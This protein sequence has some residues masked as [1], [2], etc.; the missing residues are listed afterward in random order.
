LNNVLLQPVKSGRL[1]GTL[2]IVGAITVLYFR[3]FSVN[4][5]TVALSFLL[6]VL[7]I[8]TRWGL[9]E[10]L[11]A[12]VAGMLCFNFFFIPP[13]GT[14]TIS[15]PQ[16]WVAFFAFVV[17]AA[18]TSHLS[19]SVR[20]QAQESM[21]RQH[22]MEQLYTLSRNLLLLE[23]HGHPA[24]EIT[25][26]IVQVFGIPGLAFYDRANDRMHRAGPHDIP[27]DAGKLRDC[28]LQGTV[29]HDSAAQTTLIP[30]SLG[31]QP[32]G[33]LGIQGSQVSE[34]ALHAIGN[35]TAITLERAHAQDVAT[36]A[37]AARQSEELKSTMLDALAHEF[38]TP[39]TP[40]KAAVTS[41]LS[42]TDISPAHQELLR[43]VDEETDRLNSMLTE[44]IQMSRIEA[45]RLQLHRSPQ[46]L[47]KIVKAQFDRLGERLEGRNVT[48]EVPDTLPRV[49]ADAEFVGIVIWQLLTNALRYTPPG[50]PLVLRA[51]PEATEIIVSL[52]D[53]GPGISEK[54]Q[55]KIFEKFYR[56]KDQR[57]RI[58]GTG[59]GLT[60]AREIVRAHHGRIWVESEPGKGAKFSFSVPRAPREL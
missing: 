13:V 32:I 19:A 59:M 53:Q 34:T 57:D 5:V 42:D 29:F 9:I 1:L 17:T 3:F 31:G 28:A 56:G 23:A 33:S 51:I 55:R 54:E 26:L 20:R 46:S 18:I 36:R 25:N 15:D 30:I 50:S 11:L 49:N 39:L 24:Q 41:M 21:Q 38:K 60:I 6:A 40:I 43:I 52:E 14:L 4:N 16:N 10:A 44:A 45:G 27:L 7:I 12:S 48:V 2:A 35:L 8:A 47:S 22:E 37:E 58:P